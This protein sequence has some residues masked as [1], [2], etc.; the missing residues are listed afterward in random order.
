[1]EVVQEA[2][3]NEERGTW[4][5]T[6]SPCHLVPSCEPTARAFLGDVRF[7]AERHDFP[8]SQ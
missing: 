1:M 6:L 2:D 5:V 3:A 8:K 7:A 4:L